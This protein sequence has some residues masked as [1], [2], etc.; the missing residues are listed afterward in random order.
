MGSIVSNS[1]TVMQ[2]NIDTP[3]LLDDEIKPSCGKLAALNQAQKG[4]AWMSSCRWWHVTWALA[5]D[6][7]QQ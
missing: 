1:V 3:S 2:G 7:T 5:V 4:V 6:V